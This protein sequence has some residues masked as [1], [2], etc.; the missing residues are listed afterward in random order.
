M[1]S[2]KFALERIDK[3]VE[4]SNKK[5]QALDNLFSARK[6]SQPT[7]EY[8]SKDL[9]EAIAE[10]EARRKTLAD[11]IT[12][13]IG[14]FEQQI[15][16]L[17]LLLAS[18]EIR[19]AAGEMDETLYMHENN[20]LNFGL[21]ATKQELIE[22]KEAI[23]KILSGEMSPTPPSTPSEVEK[24][25]SK[26]ETVTVNNEPP[27]VPTVTEIP[28][29]TVETPV[30]ASIQENIP[31]PAP[32]VLEVV[33]EENTRPLTEASLENTQPTLVEPPT[34]TPVEVHAETLVNE[35]IEI[36]IE[37]P[38]EVAMEEKLTEETVEASKE[39][40]VEVAPA[41]ETETV[42]EKPIEANAETPAGLMVEAPTEES[43]KPNFETTPEVY[44]EE[45]VVAP[46]EEALISEGMQEAPVKPYPFRAHL[47]TADT[48]ET[49]EEAATE[50]Q[51]AETTE[52]TH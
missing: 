41:E 7:Y 2:W 17:E 1:I 11:K 49:S 36:K 21:E 3:E 31:V 32:A 42:P 24:A 45:T 13:K 27:E 52:Q 14:E 34:E 23:V 5:K 38:E 37:Q 29:G 12:S 22:V 20:V 19:Y 25:P 4:L 33:M 10:V 28:I 6:I 8:L 44:K 15:R 50:A 9:T 40:P 18:S 16:T 43:V 35:T 39:I 26:E 47:E 30:G 51:V 46:T 48:E